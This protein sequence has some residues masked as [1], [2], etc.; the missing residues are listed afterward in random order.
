MQETVSSLCQASQPPS[1]PRLRMSTQQV[2]KINSRSRP[3]LLLPD[4]ASPDSC[5]SCRVW[6]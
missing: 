6:Q 4:R 5:L 3:S 1:H 2:V